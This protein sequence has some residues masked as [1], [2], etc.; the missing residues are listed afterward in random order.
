MPLD[1][2]GRAGLTLR[3]LGL[4]LAA[5]LVPLGSTMIAVALPAIGSEFQ[6]SA[7]ESTQWLVNSYLLVNIVALWP[8]G[9]LGDRWGYA[10]V[11]RLGQFLFGVGCVLPMVWPAFGTLVASRVLM[12]LGGALMVPTVMA[13]FRIA[14]PAERVARVL[15]YFGA[16][17]TFAAAVGPFLGGLL[18]H[19]F[20]W[21]SIFLV[22]LPPLLASVYFSLGFFRNQE[23][24]GVPPRDGAGPLPSPALFSQRSFVAGCAIVA[25]LN[26]GMYT[27]LFELPFLLQALYRAGAEHSGHLMSAFMLSMMAGSALGGRASEVIGARAACASGSLLS[28]AGFASLSLLSPGGGAWPAVAGLVLAGAGLGFANGPAHGAALATIART[29]T[30]AASGVLAISR[31]VGGIVG[32]TLLSVLLAAPGAAQSLAQ[33]HRAVLVLG[34]FVLGAALVAFWGLPRRLP[35]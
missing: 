31:Y 29:T 2:G 9:K 19:R 32:I 1:H 25:L 15:G 11:L 5:M 30:G 20:G 21:G 24:H 23:P 27:L 16:M 26:L 10:K 4:G 8:A 34:T 12:A 3:L 7:S 28:A 18:V 14:V 22:N 33:H 17:M 6:R 35:R 13:S